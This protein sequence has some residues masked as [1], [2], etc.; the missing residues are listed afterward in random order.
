ML[1]SANVKVLAIASVRAL[2]TNSK[3]CVKVLMRADVKTLAVSSIT[4][5]LF[6]KDKVKAP[7]ISRR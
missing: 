1:T 4:P 3:A 2:V 6:R 5:N 7:L